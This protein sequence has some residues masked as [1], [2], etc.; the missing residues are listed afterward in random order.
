MLWQQIKMIK[1]YSTKMWMKG[2]TNCGYTL[3]RQKGL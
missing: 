3:L 1:V 2:A